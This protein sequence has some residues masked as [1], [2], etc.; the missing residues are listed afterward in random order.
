MLF[1]HMPSHQLQGFYLYRKEPGRCYNQFKK[2]SKHHKCLWCVKEYWN[3]FQMQAKIVF[4]GREE[5]VNW[6]FI[7]CNSIFIICYLQVRREEQNSSKWWIGFKLDSQK[8]A[9]YSVREFPLAFQQLCWWYLG[10][11]LWLHSVV[12][13]VKSC[14]L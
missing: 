10:L 4:V 12:I 1:S 9:W 13:K 6:N 11:L 7:R 14:R 3:E 5:Q 2:I 8:G